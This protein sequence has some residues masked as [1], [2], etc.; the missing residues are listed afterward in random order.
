MLGVCAK[1]S[2]PNQGVSM[3][4][5]AYSGAAACEGGIP[6]AANATWSICSG[7]SGSCLKTFVRKHVVSRTLLVLVVRF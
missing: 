5:F 7:S 3:K 1:V 2:G 6:A 4:E